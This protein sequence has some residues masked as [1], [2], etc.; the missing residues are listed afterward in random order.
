MTRFRSFTTR[1][2]VKLVALLAWAVLCER[3]LIDKDTNETS[4]LFVR[5][6]AQLAS[7]ALLPANLPVPLLLVSL[8]LRSEMEKP[9]R[10]RARILVRTPSGKPIGQPLELD[11]NL[12]E[13]Y[14]LRH[15]VAF[16]A[17]IPLTEIG[18]YW[19]LVQH[20]TTAG[21]WITASRVPLEISLQPSRTGDSNAT[22]PPSSRPRG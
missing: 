5:E 7:A 12:T 9:E 22:A 13:R 15:R 10:S 17:G 11:L 14:A 20:Q 19:F 4:L 21:R 3:C 1:C 2:E 6:G 18:F 16:A 8:W